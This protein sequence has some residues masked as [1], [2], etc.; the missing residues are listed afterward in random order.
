MLYF[1]TIS[2][3]SCFGYED[4]F[5]KTVSASKNNKIPLKYTK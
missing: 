2:Y 1:T 5:Q 3:N 4:L